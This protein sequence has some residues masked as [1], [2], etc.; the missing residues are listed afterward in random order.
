M[1]KQIFLLIK[2]QLKNNGINNELSLNVNFSK[3]NK[4]KHEPWY[5]PWITNEQLNLP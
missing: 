1:I 5:G 3:R 4:L 2:K